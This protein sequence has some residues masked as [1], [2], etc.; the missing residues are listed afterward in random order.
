MCRLFTCLLLCILPIV[1]TWATARPVI[2][3]ASADSSPLSKPDDTGFVDLVVKEAFARIGMDLVIVHL[4]SERSLINANE[5]IEQG[6]FAR[7][8]GMESFYPNLVRV[9]EKI[10]DF[11]FVAFT[12]GVEVPIDGW[13][14][15]LPYT[16]GIITGWKIL[17]MNVRSDKE[18]KR[19]RTPEILFDMLVQGRVEL[20]VYN[21]I[22]GLG[23]IKE[24]G[25]KGVKA[26]EPPLAVREMFLYLHRS[27][28]A[29]VP[30]VAEV[31]QS[32]KRDGTYDRLRETVLKPYTP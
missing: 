7:I 4:P 28:E 2:H 19:V 27:Q 20:I 26:L 25:L 29:L 6:N 24:M 8:E 15:L 13:K 1:P 14:S 23:I 17:E 22:N 10:I 12:T 16:V 9:P 32:M 21:R 31:L 18:V 11:E 5:G 30:R 3:I